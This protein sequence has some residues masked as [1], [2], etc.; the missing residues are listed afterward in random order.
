MKHLLL[1]WYQVI[2]NQTIHLREFVLNSRH[3]DPRRVWKGGPEG[4][5]GTRSAGSGGSGVIRGIR[6]DPGMSSKKC[7]V[8]GRHSTWA[9]IASPISTHE[10]NHEY[11][12]CIMNTHDASWVLMMHPICH[13]VARH[14]S[15]EEF[16]QTNLDDFPANV[17]TNSPR[18]YFSFFW[19]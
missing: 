12:W 17:F 5:W 7:F 18:L 3:P 2:S 11:S 19:F 16:N 14:G 4:G 8:D 10:K 13:Q 6:G 9:F 1:N 15:W